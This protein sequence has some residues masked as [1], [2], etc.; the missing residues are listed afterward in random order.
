MEGFTQSRQSENIEAS[1]TWLLVTIAFAH[2]TQSIVFF[3][4]Q[5]HTDIVHV[6][7]MCVHVRS[8]IPL[9]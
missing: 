8:W 6:R 5:S 3:G 7:S 4:S 9:Y 2:E 1:L